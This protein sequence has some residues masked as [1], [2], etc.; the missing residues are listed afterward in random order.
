MLSYSLTTCYKIDIFRTTRG[1]SF[2]RFTDS[3]RLG[4]SSVDLALGSSPL[5]EEMGVG[6]VCFLR[7]GYSGTSLRVSCWEVLKVVLPSCWLALLSL[8]FFL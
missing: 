8:Y 2:P 7:E 6:A 5:A 1:V 3:L 4:D